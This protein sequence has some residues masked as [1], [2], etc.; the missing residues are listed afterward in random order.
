MLQLFSLQRQ[1]VSPERDGENSNDGQE[2]LELI[3]AFQ[4]N[5]DDSSEDGGDTSS[6]DDLFC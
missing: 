3:M 1:R 4:R 2:L 5:S 6:Q